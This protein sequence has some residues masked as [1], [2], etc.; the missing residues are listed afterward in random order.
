MCADLEWRQ[1]QARDAL[2]AELVRRHEGLVADIQKRLSQTRH[3]RQESTLSSAAIAAPDEATTLDLEHPA[4]SHPPPP[5]AL[6]CT[7]EEPPQKMTT[8][9]AWEPGRVDVMTTSQP[10]SVGEQKKLSARVPVDMSPAVKLGL[11]RSGTVSMSLRQPGRPSQRPHCKSETDRSEATCEEDGA[12]KA[13]ERLFCKST[14]IPTRSLNELVDSTQCEMV[15]GSCIVLNGV[16][17]AFEVQHQG[18]KLGYDLEYRK[19]KSSSDPWPNSQDV[20]KAAGMFFGIIFMLELILKLSVLRRKFFLHCWNIF[21]MLIVLGWLIETLPFLQLDG[22]AGATVFRVARLARLM[23]LVR[24]VRQIR[25]F[26]ALFLMTTAIQSSITVLFWS[27]VL[28]FMLQVL[29]AFLLN[30]IL[31]WTYFLDTSYPLEERQEIFVYFGTFSRAMLS[32]F[33]M[34]LANWPPVCRLL[35]ENVSEWFMVF[36]LLHKLTIGFAVIGIINGVFI[37]ETFRVAANDDF[38]MMHEKEWSM[39]THKSKMMKLLEAG[40]SSGD[41][42]LDRGEFLELLE[43]DEVKMWLA[44]MDLDTSDG[45]AVFAFMD[46]DGDNQVS[47]DE[48]VQG[49][50]KL[51]GSARSL[52]L[53]SCLHRIDHLTKLIIDL[54]PASDQKETAIKQHQVRENTE[55][56]IGTS[57]FARPA[58]LP[59]ICSDGESHDA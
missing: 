45:E 3:M 27:V 12:C 26:D 47:I 13:S 18:L 49:V 29:C 2:K 9:P 54:T 6:P 8:L 7:I 1:G 5:G 34:T 33:E 37:Q 52:D 23:R 20:F 25:T 4:A 36:C 11:A 19:Y 16:L 50:S 44:S 31:H 17:M 39:G 24:V 21:D 43:V 10:L 35:M 38:I 46:K 28:L 51:K 42:Q 30:Q 57:R 55:S 40:D 53:I 58:A 48:L 22:F 15:I 14:A 59:P 32:T 56:A 41:G